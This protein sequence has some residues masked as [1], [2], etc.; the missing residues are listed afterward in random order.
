[1][2]H[3]ILA[4]VQDGLTLTP[5]QLREQWSWLKNEGYQCLSI[6]DFLSIARGAETKPGKCFLLTFDDGYKD[7]LTNAYPLLQEFKWQATLFLIGDTLSENRERT[8]ENDSDLLSLEELKTMDPEIMSIGMHG[9]HH[10]NFSKLEPQKA[11]EAIEDMVQA[12]EQSGLPY[13]KVMAYPY[14]ARPKGV[15]ESFLLKALLEDAGIEAAFRI[16]NKPERVPSMDIYELKRIDIRGEDS[17]DDFKIKL[18]KGK[19]KP[20]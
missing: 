1:M 12:F 4:G 11:K 20:F 10:E 3:R 13:H 6:E 19:L 2:Y 16:G 18:R 8:K 15:N 14:G 9:F 5:E 7:N 17:I